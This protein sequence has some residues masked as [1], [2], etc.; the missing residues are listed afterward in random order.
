MISITQKA[1]HISAPHNK[2]LEFMALRELETDNSQYK[3]L[4][5]LP[6]F[7][8]AEE[9][10]SMIGQDYSGAG[11]SELVD[12]IHTTVNGFTKA[13]VLHELAK[14]YGMKLQ[15]KENTI[16]DLFSQLSG[17]CFW[18]LEDA[19]LFKY[20]KVSSFQGMNCLIF[21]N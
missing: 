17:N 11:L 15:I 1:L 20:E 6:K 4:S 19:V 13:L 10:C 3:S 21:E 2:D 9:D 16:E 8:N 7:M 18:I 12:V 14:R 5:D